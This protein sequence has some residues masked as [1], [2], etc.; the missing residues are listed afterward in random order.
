MTDQQALEHIDQRMTEARD[1]EGRLSAKQAT[2]D[3]TRAAFNEAGVLSGPLPDRVRKLADELAAVT[4]DRNNLRAE[5]TQVREMLDGAGIA[6]DTIPAAVA[7]LLKER[8]EWRARGPEV[9]GYVDTPSYVRVRDER[10]RLRVEISDLLT[11][12]AA[13]RDLLDRAG[14]DGPICAMVAGLVKGRTPPAPDVA[15]GGVGVE[16][17]IGGYE[18]SVNGENVG[19]IAYCGGDMWCT[20]RVGMEPVTRLRD[21]ATARAVLLA[22]AGQ[23]CGRVVFGLRES[24]TVADL[25]KIKASPLEW[26][27]DDLLLD[28]TCGPTTW[29]TEPDDVR[30]WVAHGQAALTIEAVSG[31]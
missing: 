11:E 8:A 5:R 21:D 30:A 6:S 4:A 17:G 12:R 20:F 1:A 16:W 13:V 18:L 22:L 26:V 28:P 9:F 10:D 2:I 29:T 3:M 15:P 27:Y 7:M 23:D 14:L 19:E 25:R 24:A 31:V